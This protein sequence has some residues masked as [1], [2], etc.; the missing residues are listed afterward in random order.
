MRTSVSSIDSAS[1]L[2]TGHKLLIDFVSYDA[3]PESILCERLDHRVSRSTSVV[4]K[5]QKS[6]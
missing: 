3:T 4:I 6:C 2:L 1:L 5:N